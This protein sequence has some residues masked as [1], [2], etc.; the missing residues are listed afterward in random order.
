M[1]ATASASAQHP[2]HHPTTIPSIHL[3]SATPSSTGLSSSEAPNS[4][5][6]FARAL[7]DPWAATAAAFHISLPLAPKVEANSAKK[8]L[9]PKKSKLGIFSSSPFSSTTTGG[10]G[11]TKDE[12]SD[13]VRRVGADAKSG[14][15][16]GGG[17]GGKGGFDIYVDPVFRASLTD[18]SSHPPSTTTTMAQDVHI[19]TNT[20]ALPSQSLSLPS[21]SSGS[22]SSEEDDTKK[23]FD[24]TGELAKFDK[25][26][27]SPR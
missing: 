6:T 7:E 26:R 1:Q 16:G 18:H 15:G 24:F 13:V 19:N 20:A 14:G 2:S 12:F 3:I 4:P 27:A 11:S 21:I 5:A 9:V 8:K 17:G 25:P 23:S 22:D 10:A